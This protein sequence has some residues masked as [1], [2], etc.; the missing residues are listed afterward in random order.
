[1]ARFGF[2]GPSY[3]SESPN[4]NDEECINFYTE[5]DESGD[6]KSSAALLPTPG[7]KLFSTL[8]GIYVRGQI[9]YNGRYFAVSDTKFYEIASDGT[10]TVRGTVVNDSL[11]VSMA[12]GPTQ[13]MIVSGGTAYSFEYSSNTFAVIA[14]LTDPIIQ[15]DYADGYFVALKS[16][17]DEFQI[18]ALLDCTT[19]NPIDTFQ[20]EVFPDKAL[21]ML[22]DHREIWFWG[23]K[24]TQA[25]FDTGDAN[26]PW[27]PIPGAFIETGIAAK[28]ARSKID[29]SIFWLGSSSRGQAIAWRANGYVPQRISNHAVEYAWNQYSDISN[30]ISYAYEDSGHAFWVVYFPTPSQTWVYDVS[31]GVW[32]RRN[33]WDKTTGTYVAHHG[34]NHCFAFGKHLIGDWSS[35]K[36]YEMALKYNDDDGEVIRRLRRAPHISVEQQWMYHHSLQID[37]EAGLGNQSDPGKDP[38]MVLRWSDDGGKTWSND[39]M[40]SAGKVGEYSQRAIWRR[41]GRARDRVY[42]LVV[43]D[44]IPWRIV[45]AYLDADPGF[46]PTERMTDMYRKMR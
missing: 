29:N 35:G 14:A 36:I 30:A 17:S 3:V 46:K 8:S 13:L 20:V 4:F 43:T 2:V 27:Q 1:M 37:V 38:Q 33:F 31:Q 11:P 39:H 19:W 18:S 21:S 25:Y 45:G 15:C 22:C 42:E 32:H 16:D 5:A 44:P 28:W 12:T 40:T 26:T 34:Q 6:A 7:T 9:E 24:A 10:A 41:L 23:P